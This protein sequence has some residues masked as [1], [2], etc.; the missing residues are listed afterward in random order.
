MNTPDL[1]S[2]PNRLPARND[3]GARL[4]AGA[5]SVFLLALG[6][7]V[8]PLS[9][10]PASPAAF[11]ATPVSWTQAALKWTDQSDNE[12]GFIIERRLGATGAWEPVIIT[13][14]NAVR[15]DDV[16]L[17]GAASYTYRIKAAGGAAGDSAYVMAAAITTPAAR[18]RPPIVVM[19]LGDSITRGT[20]GTQS[21]YRDPLYTLL[22]NTGYTISYVGSETTTATTLL[23]QSGNEHHEGHG[24]YSISA[25]SSGVDGATTGW[26][27]GVP[28]TRDPLYP[29]VILLMAGTND[30]GTGASSGAVAL[31]RM[32]AL[33]T[34]L[35]TLRPAA[36]IVVGTLVP[37]YGTHETR[38]QRQLDYNAGLPALIAAHQ[39][40]GRRVWLYDMR[41]KVNQPSQISSDGVHPNQSGYHAIAAGWFEAWRNLPMIETWRHAKFGSAAGAGAAADLADADGDGVYNVIEY[42]LGG[43]PKAGGAA[44]ALAM[45]RPSLVQDGGSAYLALTFPRRRHADVGYVVESA[46]IPGAASVW[47]GGAV[48]LGAPVI[49]DSN[50]EQVTCRDPFA[51]GSGARR[52]LRLRVVLP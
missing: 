26:L 18:K 20:G 24:G 14:S 9:A 4:A 8:S 5:R 16:G 37:Y 2:A 43:D 31:T 44:N 45:P 46:E 33:L 35:T 48:Q 7:A 19:P 23:T 30:I 3:V 1:F 13:A 17:A 25:I 50:F 22:K 12:T 39:A 29:D 28:G 40:A 6:L 11:V 38:E 10:A 51:L 34:K 27:T 21:G 15:V 32:D 42:A 52:F 41:T 36:L 47:S 49:L